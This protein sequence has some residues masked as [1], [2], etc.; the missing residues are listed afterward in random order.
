[1]LDRVGHITWYAQ[2]RVAGGGSML[3]FFYHWASWGGRDA[4]CG[5][6][7]TLPLPPSLHLPPFLPAPLRT[8]RVYSDGG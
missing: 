2:D 6:L 8:I 4:G 3:G 5:D 7:Q 1:M